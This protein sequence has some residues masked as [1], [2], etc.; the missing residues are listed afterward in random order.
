[1]GIDGM[2]NGETGIGKE[3][4]NGNG[5]G[6]GD[7][8]L[9]GKLKLEIDIFSHELFILGFHLTSEK[10]KIKIFSFYL[11]QVKVIFKH[12]SVGPS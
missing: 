11:Y 10:T 6:D 9:N 7:G 1:M 3:N 8:K 12:V 4:G 5:Y 2:E